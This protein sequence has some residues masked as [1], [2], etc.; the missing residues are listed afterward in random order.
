MD[1]D[2]AQ[3]SSTPKHAG[4]RPPKFETPEQLERAIELYYETL[5]GD[6]DHLDKPPTL[7]GLARALGFESRQSLVDYKEKPEFTYIIKEAR[8]RIEEHHEGRLSGANSTGSICWLNN[9]A[10]Y[11]TRQE[12]TGANGGPIET[13]ELNQEERAARI[14]EL[15][16][17]AKA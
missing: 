3:T 7:A 10:G 8:M 14:A 1:K 4:G 5:E 11:V 17:K 12:I 6:K 9:H 16:A 13:H 15:L 2:S